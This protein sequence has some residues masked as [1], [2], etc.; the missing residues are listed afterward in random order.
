MTPTVSFAGMGM[1][2]QVKAKTV[3]ATLA[4]W[5]APDFD[6][7]GAGNVR[8]TEVDPFGIADTEILQ[9]LDRQAQEELGLGGRL[10][11][12]EE[13]DAVQTARAGI[14]DRGLIMSQPAAV[15]DVLARDKYARERQD[16]RRG[17]AAGVSGMLTQNDVF[18]AQQGQ[19]AALAN[20]DANLRAALANQGTGLS[21][22]TTTAELGNRTAL[23]DQQA[24]NTVALANEENRLRAEGGNQSAALQVGQVNAQGNLQAGIANQGAAGDVN[25]LR[26]EDE[27][28][29]MADAT[30][31]YGIS[32]RLASSGGGYAGPVGGYGTRA[33]TGGGGDD[34]GTMMGLAG[35]PADTRPYTPL[36]GS[37]MLYSRSTGYGVP[38]NA[39]ISRVTQGTGGGA[40]EPVYSPTAR[41]YPANR[42]G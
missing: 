5:A 42:V 4:N 18:N 13:R 25:R 6:Q 2:A 34:W 30:E 16:S 35:L 40:Q 27:W 36:G 17:F 33:N 32:S 20:Q 3:R 24:L 10:S 12:Q 31:R 29:R 7:F 39:G 22:W 28:R 8:A 37:R 15:A 41:Y 9:E 1:P 21:R 38:Y 19:G 14:S 11:A 26:L 23:A